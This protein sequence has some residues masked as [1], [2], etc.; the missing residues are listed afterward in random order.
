MGQ[1]GADRE[2]ATEEEIAEMGRLAEGGYRRRARVYNVADAQSPHQH[3]GTYAHSERGS[4]RACRHC[5]GDR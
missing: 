1:R 4:Q 2:P 5:E 3:W